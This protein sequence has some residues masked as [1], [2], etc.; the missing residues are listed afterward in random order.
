MPRAARALPLLLLALAPATAAVSA[1][2][3]PLV[4]RLPASAR[5]LALGGIL[6]PGSADAAAIFYHPAFPAA[7]IGAG[8]QWLGAD[9]VA[10]DAAGAVEWLGGTVGLGL[11]TASY[12]GPFRSATPL[13][14]N[15]LMLP[16]PVSERA[17]QV[18]YGRTLKGIRLALSGKYV[19]QRWD[20]D[21]SARW[22]V[23]ASAGTTAGPVRLAATAQNLGPDLDVG[24]VDV[25][26]NRRVLVAVA[27][28]GGAPLG[29]LDVLPTLQVAWERG[30]R[31]TPAAG[32]EL[33][34]WP[35]VGRTFFL[36]GGVRRPD[37]GE[38][39]FTLGAGFAGDRIALDYGVAPLK[40][41]RATHRV[42]LR[43]R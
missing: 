43:W 35:V 39:P 37:A 22:A 10:F 2:D 33:G 8:A 18:T 32:V 15:Q 4:L 38:R 1:Q 17:A 19:D 3:A 29:P 27:P 13:P 7:G 14:A 21:R 40:G 30:Q 36:R 41:G 34:Y 9:T 5:A 12:T 11:R 28:P 26:L 16:Q 6:P 24:G 20:R 31:F 23:D 25:P 42:G